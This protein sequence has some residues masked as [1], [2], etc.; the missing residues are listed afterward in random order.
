MKKL[1]PYQQ[2]QIALESWQGA[3][4]EEL[5]KKWGQTPRAIQRIRSRH[6]PK[7]EGEEF[8]PIKSHGV[9]QG[10]YVVSDQNRVFMAPDAPPGRSPGWAKVI[11]YGQV[12]LQVGPKTSDLKWFLVDE[13][14]KAAWG[15]GGKQ[16]PGLPIPEQP[17]K[18][19]LY[20]C[21]NAQGALLYIGITVSILS[22]TYQHLNNEP[23]FAEV[24]DMKLQH[25]T[26]ML[27]SEARAIEE[28][29]ILKEHPLY[30]K[31]H[32]SNSVKL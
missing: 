7:I 6:P 10:L 25:L 24:V 27:N 5:C 26:A 23:W 28:L 22:R 3:S 31:E 14:R 16:Q 21:Y 1:T 32:N 12:Q 13:L 9:V 17:R 30:N 11:K 2:Q 18:R 15:K 8:R 19:I 20:R 29:A 4:V